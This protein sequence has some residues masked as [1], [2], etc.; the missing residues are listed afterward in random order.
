ME[1]AVDEHCVQQF[2]ESDGRKL[3]ST[4]KEDL[5]IG[6]EG[7]KEKDDDAKEGQ[8]MQLMPERIMRDRVE[9]TGIT[10]G[11][12]ADLSEAKK[13]EEK[14]NEKTKEKTYEGFLR[15]DWE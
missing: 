5:D 10:Q 4:A 9:T 7:K 2:D 15:G 14:T 1:V 8:A 11:D 12:N 3:R 13:S 6:D